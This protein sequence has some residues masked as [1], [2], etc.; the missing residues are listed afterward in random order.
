SCFSF[1]L[2]M[3]VAPLYLAVLA[4]ACCVLCAQSSSGQTIIVSGNNPPFYSVDTNGCMMTPIPSP[5]RFLGQFASYLSEALH[6]DTLYYTTEAGVLC[7]Y[8]LGD[9]SSLV[10]LRVNVNTAALTIDRNGFL[11]WVENENGPT[12]I[13]YNPH[14]DEKDTLGAM[15]YSP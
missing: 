8:I 1:F 6:G 7:R 15:N 11:Y 14:S 3:K 4:I 5:T 13:R 10:E 12:L 2:V 9:T